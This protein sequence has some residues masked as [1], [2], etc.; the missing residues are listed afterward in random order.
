MAG[1]PQTRHWRF[2]LRIGIAAAVCASASAAQAG[3]QAETKFFQ[4]NVQSTGSWTSDYFD[5]RLEPGITTGAGVDGRES[6]NWRWQVWAVA[7]HA[8]GSADPLRSTRA[9]IRAR[10]GYAGNL[11]AW[12]ILMSD[13]NTT[14]LGC[15]DGTWR[16]W[17][18]EGAGPPSRGD[19][20]R[21]RDDLTVD[22]E[23]HVALTPL[24]R[25]ECG[26]HKSEDLLFDLGEVNKCLP[27]YS[28][29]I[30][31]LPRGAFNPRFDRSFEKTF[32]CRPSNLPPDHGTVVDLNQ[33][34]SVSYSSEVTLSIEKISEGKYKRRHARY[35]DYPR[36]KWSVERPL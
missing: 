1:E 33:L 36:G 6:R 32:R 34:H 3:S 2:A 13:L 23:L 19:I 8:G 14:P 26:Y 22:G 25:V 28:V 21:L 35:A 29:V 18:K 30:E 7:K 9:I 17:D 24:I 12:T 27:Q 5:D 4:V 31:R 10:T 16:S 11:V 15:R 20:I